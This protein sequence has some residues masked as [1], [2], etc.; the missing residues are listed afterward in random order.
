MEKTHLN[1]EGESISIYTQSTS[2]DIRQELRTV[3]KKIKIKEGS[4][5]S[6]HGQWKSQSDIRPRKSILIT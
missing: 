3:L 5:S 2:C 1:P 6:C 4:N